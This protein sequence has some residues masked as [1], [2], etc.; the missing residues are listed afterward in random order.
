MTRYIYIP[1]RVID[2]NGIADGAR[3]FF[4]KTETTTLVDIFFD[5]EMTYPL[6]NPLVVDLGAPVP[7]VYWDEG[8][9]RVVVIGRNGEIVSDDDPYS[10]LGSDAIIAINRIET[11]GEDT[12]AALVPFL[13]SGI[14]VSFQSSQEKMRENPTLSDFGAFGDGNLHTVSEWIVPGVKGR[15]PN[16]EAVQFDYPHVTSVSDDANWAALTKAE[17]YAKASGTGRVDLGIGN[18]AY[19]KTWELTTRGIA[20]CGVVGFQGLGSGSVPSTLTWRGGA[21]PMIRT[22]ATRYRF[23][24]F[25]IR[26]LGSATDFHECASGSQSFH[27]E[28]LYCLVTGHNRFTRAFIHSDGNRVGYS[29]MREC[30][31]GNVAPVII[32]IDGAATPNNIT[33]III[34]GRC[35]FTADAGLG[36]VTVVKLI[37]EGIE[38]LTIRDCSFNQYTNELIIV[39]TRTT[40]YTRPIDVFVFEA[41]E[42]DALPAGDATAFRNFYLTNVSQILFDANRISAGGS[43][44]FVADLVNSH[45][46]SCRGTYTS[47]L[48]SALFNCDDAST[49]RGFYT[50][51]TGVGR[52]AF[53][54]R[55]AGIVQ[56]TYAAGVAID[57]RRLDQSK[58]E[59]LYLDVTNGSG[60]SISVDN[61]SPEFWTIGQVFTVVIRNVSSAAIAGGTFNAVYFNTQGATVAPAVGFSRSYTFVWDGTK[62]IELSR[63]TADVANS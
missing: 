10:P 31:I 47:S 60:Y 4:Y 39:D 40:T 6:P 41:N 49:V 8:L 16:L 13:P 20:V 46:V 56:L 18:F 14:S 61:T 59:V 12:G 38:N 35:I 58:H 29:H 45:V 63:S 19:S 44:T 17:E 1:N 7:A 24:D 54:N 42:I 50:N 3:I 32:N 28:R 62:A 22:S 53:I 25:A 48:N 21:A 27:W 52:N 15:Y 55:R 33:N 34:D 11:A 23:Q 30:L 26:N 57:G 37:D 5:E 51:G 9:V 2:S 43:K 36:P